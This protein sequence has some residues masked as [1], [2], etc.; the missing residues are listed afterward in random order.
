MTVDI[1]ILAVIRI[2]CWNVLTEDYKAS[3]GNSGVIVVG[4]AKSRELFAV[5]KWVGQTL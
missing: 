3:T 4:G 5:M 2:R 1:T